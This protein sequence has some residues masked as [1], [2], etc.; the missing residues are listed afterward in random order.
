M[1]ICWG[2]G[3][4]CAERRAFVARVVISCSTAS[5]ADAVP[6]YES[7]LRDETDPYLRQHMR[8][9]VD[10]LPRGGD[11]FALAQRLDRPIVLSSSYSACHWCGVMAHESFEDAEK[12]TKNARGFT[13]PAL[14]FGASAASALGRER[15][16]KS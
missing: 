1:P 12:G 6:T 14:A 3:S 9:P 11:A 10:W 8:N 5:L 7:R 4:R 15:M 2:V 16:T 13:T